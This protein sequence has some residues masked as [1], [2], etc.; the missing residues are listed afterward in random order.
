M[1]KSRLS[2]LDGNGEAYMVDVGGKAATS[3]Y[4]KASGILRMRPDTLNL[5]RG[6]KIKKGDA[7][8]V[9][10]TAGM[11]AVKKTPELIPLC[12]P[13]P[14]E[15][16]E[17]KFRDLPSKDGVKIEVEVRTTSKTGVE[18]E[19]I[20]GV[21]MTALTLYDMAKASDPAMTITDVRLIKKTGGKSDFSFEGG[22]SNG[23]RQVLPRGT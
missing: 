9:A 10:K 5:M 2:H 1:K 12:H 13:L 7:F 23:Q 14:L 16:I 6:G 21:L 22:R 18:I 20:H 4:A 15:Q 8:T 17:I 11:L 19:A 3:R